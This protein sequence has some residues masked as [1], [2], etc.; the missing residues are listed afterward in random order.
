MTTPRKTNG[1]TSGAPKRSSGERSE[2]EQ[3]GG[4]PEAPPRT[5]TPPSSPPPDPEVPEKARRRRF[6]AEYKLWI[7]KEVDAARDTGEI[8]ALLRRE[9]LYSSHLLTWRRQREEGSLE[10][11]GAKK[12]GRKRKDPLAQ[13]NEELE[14]ENQKLKESL[15][16]AHLLLELQK[17]VAD[18]LGVPL[19]APPADENK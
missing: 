11:L 2:T 1:T 9:A 7:L 13:R 17:K 10:A 8:G 14:K 12:R 18:I 16:K 19:N 5:S 15:K 3:S 6:T 4:A